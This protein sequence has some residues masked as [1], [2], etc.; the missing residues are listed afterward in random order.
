MGANPPSPCA[1]KRDEVPPIDVITSAP[2][3][4][5]SLQRAAD[6]LG[7]SNRTARR[8]AIEGRFPVAVLKV[9]GR[10]MVRSDQ[11]DE[12]LRNP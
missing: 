11:L 1:A 12:F 9:G 5:C 10:W 7:I 6:R 4:L 2:C 8:L 3:V